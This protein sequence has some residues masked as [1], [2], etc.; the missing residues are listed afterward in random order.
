MAFNVHFPLIYA[1]LFLFWVETNFK[2][3]VQ[4]WSGI[5]LGIAKQVQGDMCAWIIE[6]ARV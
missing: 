5:I 3:K 6:G 2:G 4:I 1:I